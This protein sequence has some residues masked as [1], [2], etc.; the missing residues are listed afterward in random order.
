MERSGIGSLIVSRCFVDILRKFPD[1]LNIP[2]VRMKSRVLLSAAALIVGLIFVSSMAAGAVK[3]GFQ[4]TGGPTYLVG[5]DLNATRIAFDD[6]ISPGRMGRFHLG[7]EAGA[8]FLVFLSPET[9]L[10]F[11]AGYVTGASLDGRTFSGGAGRTQD[12]MDTNL[13]AYAVLAGVLQKIAAEGR[14]GL[15]IRA[16]AG[17]YR[18]RWTEIWTT[19]QEIGST[20]SESTASGSGL[21]IHGGLTAAF[22]VS[23]GFALIAEAGGRWIDPKGFEGSVNYTAS[24]D[25]EETVG[26]LYFYEYESAKGKWTPW[27]A[28]MDR[29][30]I[31]KWSEIRRDREAKIGFTGLSFRLGFR[32]RL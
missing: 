28:V 24:G 11:G 27:I 7:G 20:V 9:A 22:Q 8:E 16:G 6:Y 13:R 17:Y 10:S 5:A 12:T 29:T 32:V 31:E 2:K 25:S 19:V 14:W 21:G 15:E 18:G 23:P 3:F 4:L 26:T 1:F 30:P